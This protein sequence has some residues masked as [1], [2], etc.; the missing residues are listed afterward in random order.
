MLQIIARRRVGEHLERSGIAIIHH[1][2]I[3]TNNHLELQVFRQFNRNGVAG[4][5]IELQD[6]GLGKH[7]RKDQEKHQDHHHVDHRH[8]VQIIAPLVI[9]GVIASDE[10]RSF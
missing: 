3:G 8:D 1:E 10:A 9:A 5:Q 7:R 2:V 4:R 6:I